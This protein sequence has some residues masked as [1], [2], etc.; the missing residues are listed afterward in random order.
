MK[1]YKLK[2]MTNGWFVGDFNPTTYSVD[3]EVGYKFH[4]KGET[5][6]IHY[7]KESD[8]ITLLVRGRM[9]IQDQIL[10]SGDIFVIP[11]Y[12][13]ADPIFLEDCYTVVVK[14]K[15]QTKDKY[16]LSRINPSE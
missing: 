11:K 5:W 7:H 10:E 13:I 2:D 9:K 6:D 3:F 12:E 16:C 8:E 15:S 4:E 1:I 14:T